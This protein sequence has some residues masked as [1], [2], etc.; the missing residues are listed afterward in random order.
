[1]DARVFAVAALHQPI[2]LIDSMHLACPSAPQ[3][4]LAV[5]TALHCEFDLQD[6]SFIS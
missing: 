4:F 2:Q 6:S 5:I 1:M 3:S